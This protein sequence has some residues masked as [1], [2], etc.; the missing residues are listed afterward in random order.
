MIIW[1][2]ELPS[3]FVGDDP[4]LSFCKKKHVKIQWLRFVWK[5]KNYKKKYLVE[6]I[7]E[8]TAAYRSLAVV[9]L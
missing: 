6:K 3:V 8:N 7:R 4:D 2:V 9:L 1:G 5:L